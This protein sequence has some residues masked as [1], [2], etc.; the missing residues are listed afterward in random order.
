MSS[1]YNTIICRYGE[2]AL[3]KGNRN[4]FEN[5]LVTNITRLLRGIDNLKIDR[6]R[7][8]MSLQHTD[9]SNFTEEEFKIIDKQLQKAFGLYSYSPAIMVEPNI[10]QIKDVVAKTCG[11][12]FDKAL[13]TKPSGVTF[14]VRARRSNKSFPLRSAEIELELADVI[15]KY[16]ERDRLNVNL[17][18]SDITIGCE[19]RNEYAFIYY[20]NIKAP[21]GL[22]VSPKSP[23]LAMLSG[24]IDSPVACYQAMKRGCCVDYIT[25]HSAPYT[26]QESVDK[27]IKLAE[28]LNEFQKPGRL[29]IANMAIIQKAIRDNC[30]ERLRTILYRRAMMRISERVATKRQ[31]KALLTGEAIGQ[32]ASQTLDNMNTIQNATDMVIIRP[33]ITMDK[34]DIIE[35]AQKIETFDISAIQCMDSCTVFAP[36][37]AATTSKI[38]RVVEEEA[39]I[40]NYNELIDQIVSEIEVV[41]PD[42]L[43]GS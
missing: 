18:D 5:W 12:I 26:T 27:V 13:E 10:D 3:K 11:D 35:I 24:G 2:L 33:L 34:E 19:V 38:Y 37:S 6:V 16:I 39:K 30:Q 28:I 36:S 4:Q 40:E 15:G 14:K 21:G 8:R 20:E 31:C 23:V 22:P 1:I 29:H 25:F 32:V 41:K 7:G 9:K 42:A 43:I 17:K